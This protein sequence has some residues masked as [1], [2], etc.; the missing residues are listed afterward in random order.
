MQ[1]PIPNQQNARPFN[2]PT[3][4]VSVN[5]KGAATAKKGGAVKFIIPVVAV[6]L[7]IALIIGVAGSGGSGGRGSDGGNYP[8]PD[9]TYTLMVYMVGSNLE[10]EENHAAS[11]DLREIAASGVDLENVNVIVYAGGSYSWS[12]PISSS[13]KNYLKLYKK[14]DG[15]LDYQNLTPGEPGENMSAPQAFTSF[16]NYTVENY[17]ADH[18]GLI[19]WNHGAGTYGFGMDEVY[20]GSDDLLTLEEMSSGFDASPFG[21]G[22][23]LDWLGFDACLMGTVEV[24]HCLKDYANYMVASEDSEDAEGWDYS[25]VSNLNRTFDPV[26]VSESVVDAF[27]SFYSGYH[28]PYIDQQSN[29]TLSVYDLSKTDGVYNGLVNYLT[30]IQN[31]IDQGD[32]SVMTVGAKDIRSFARESGYSLYD[33]VDV[34]DSTADS[35]P[36]ESAAVKSAVGEMVIKN[37]STFDRCSGVSFFYEPPGSYD[38]Y[39]YGEYDDSSYSEDSYEYD[40]DYGYD[41]Y[42]YDEYGYGEYYDEIGRAV[43][44]NSKEK[45]VSW[46]LGKVES[47]GVAA[48]LNLTGEQLDDLSEAYYNVLIDTGDE[49]GEVYTPVMLKAKLEPD[50]D[51]NLTVPLNTELIT[52]QNIYEDKA[53]KASIFPVMQTGKTKSDE[54][55]TS[56]RAIV[57][58]GFPSVIEG[59]F[60]H[61]TVGFRK[62]GE[63]NFSVTSIN[64]E[65]SG[66]STTGKNTVQAA[67]WESIGYTFKRCIP[68]KKPFDEWG[69]DGFFNTS[70]SY[71]GSDIK[72]STGSTEMFA[73]DFSA[74]IVVVDNQGNRYATKLF[75]L[76]NIYDAGL[77]TATVK[78]KNG[79]LTFELSEG[80]AVLKSYE[81][82]DK[83][84]EIPSQVE[85]LNVVK[86]GGYAF[87]DNYFSNESIEK[88]NL[89]ETVTELGHGALSCMD[90]L[91]TVNVP[92]KIT[93]IPDN[94]FKNDSSLESVTLP[95]GVKRIGRFAFSS[96]G[97]KSFD[98]PNSV[99]SIDVGGFAWSALTKITVAGKEA[100]DNFKVAG[101]TMLL[102]AD[103]KE[104]V[105]SA[106]L[107]ENTQKVEIPAGV[108][109]IRDYAFYGVVK[110]K[111]VSLNEDE[112]Y[113]TELVLPEGLKEI[114]HYAFR[115]F[116]MLKEIK[117]PSTLTTIGELAFSSI[118]NHVE[119]TLENVE[120]GAKVAKIGKKAFAGYDVKAFSV[121]GGNLY[122]SSVDGK[123]MNKGGD[124]E[125][126]VLDKEYDEPAVKGTFYDMKG[127]AYSTKE[128]VLYYTR[129]GETYIIKNGNLCDAKSGKEIEDKSSFFYID[130]DGYLVT[131]DSFKDYEKA[132]LVSARID[133]NG[134]ILFAI[135]DVEWNRKGK[136]RENT[137]SENEFFDRDGKS[138]SKRS[139]VPY[140]TKDGKVYYPQ[141]NENSF[142][143]TLVEKDTENVVSRQEAFITSDGYL[144]TTKS[145]LLDYIYTD[146]K[147]NVYY[148][149]YSVEWNKDGKLVDIYSK[150]VLN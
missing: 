35:T 2:S 32:Y 65:S 62:D 3:G 41:G 19:C 49:K 137:Y 20:G 21:S 88:L 119:V 141:L 57:F 24:A 23:K 95:E 46:K 16:L 18:Y 149:Y 68:E 133:E 17:P 106:N 124:V 53:E 66:I 144:L 25:F 55:Y 59:S 72:F 103:G 13:N 104:V 136:L 90:K 76:N 22:N 85:G 11:N 123:L 7:V 47:D 69:N 132:N 54:S 64:S 87:G 140:Y 121:N 45:N 116:N 91:K 58:R 8:K 28:N 122:Y 33:V 6:L 146:F 96:T 1:R 105:C 73:D 74:Q 100:G 63:N 30:S 38:E 134:E 92:G 10:N 80:G 81:G 29:A 107:P 84:I 117:L 101:G 142:I 15:T 94:C 40:Y 118:M 89:P 130:S 43:R 77:K 9:G 110:E 93:N 36:E 97:L 44:K 70:F 61:V 67:D 42:E 127:K 26:A 99:E 150:K 60:D 108:E 138:Y 34:V 120:I 147:G 83:E 139:E 12:M 51:G 27:A 98:I 82:G 52:I 125:I 115:G 131:F 86:I 143:D 56:Y 5:G 71:I 48:K 128:E 114:G 135:N 113:T 4:N 112:V 145:S 102:T 79:K 129:S 78:T 50:S 148:G 37:T 39:G 14:D 109:K 126:E 111:F 75:G 31:K